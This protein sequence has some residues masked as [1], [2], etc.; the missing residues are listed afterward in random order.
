[1]NDASFAD[2]WRLARGFDDPAVLAEIALKTCEGS[3]AKVD[4]KRRNWISI[5]A[6]L[7]GAEA[8]EQENR[9]YK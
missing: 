5:S 3:I 7:G 4:A 8:T 2:R 9:H 1:M 6:A